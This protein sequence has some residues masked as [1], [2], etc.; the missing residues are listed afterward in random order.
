VRIFTQQLATATAAIEHIDHTVHATHAS[1]AQLTA[2]DAALPPLLAYTHSQLT[3]HMAAATPLWQ[4]WQQQSDT[5]HAALD[6]F[7][8]TITALAHIPLPLSLSGGRNGSTLLECVDERALR[9]SV[10]RARR[11]K[12]KS[13]WKRND[14]RR[15][16]ENVA[17]ALATIRS[18]LP[19]EEEAQV[20]AV[21]DGWGGSGSGG[22]S[23]D[24]SSSSSSSSSRRREC[25]GWMKRLMEVR[26]EAQHYCQSI[27][28]RLQSAAASSP[29]VL[30]EL[31]REVR[32]KQMEMEGWNR[33]NREAEE[34]GCLTYISHYRHAA[35][36]LLS[37]AASLFAHH[38]ASLTHCFTALSALSSLSA[39][40]PLYRRLLAHSMESFTP[41]LRLTRLSQSYSQSLSEVSRRQ[42]RRQRRQR[43]VTTV[44]ER[45]KQEESEERERRMRWWQQWGVNLPVGM[46]LGLKEESG[47]VKVEVCDWDGLLPVVTDEEVSRARQQGK[48]GGGGEMEETKEERTDEKEQ[49]DDDEAEDDE[50]AMK[51]KLKRLQ[52][53][54]ATLQAELLRLRQQ[55]QQQQPTITPTP[56]PATTTAAAAEELST[57]RTEVDRRQALLNDA[58]KTNAWLEEE[59]NKR[60]EELTIERNRRDKSER[61]SR[62]VAMKL[63][64]AVKE[65]T[66]ERLRYDECERERSGWRE[67]CSERVVLLQPAVNDMVMAVRVAG[68]G[69]GSSGGGSMPVYR[70][71]LAGDGGRPMF[72]SAETMSV[73]REKRSGSSSGGSGV[74][75]EWVVGHVVEL[76]GKRATGSVRESEAGLKIGE[77]YWMATV[78]LVDFLER[79]PTSEGSNGVEASSSSTQSSSSSVSSSSS[80]PSPS[81]ST[82]TLDTLLLATP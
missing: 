12:D 56:P 28:A 68:G 54:N 51:D 53:D 25:V 20:R 31:E 15:Q 76:V 50:L 47:W 24:S 8:P 60:E 45:W 63:V 40:L 30:A 19:Q 44:V 75:A 65:R 43:A 58:N 67:R 10:E 3:Q 61:D 81:P 46:Q 79:L 82:A 34:T 78:A 33:R 16:E 23:G 80:S 42:R 29:L 48:V 59:L 36:Q 37:F 9:E 52:A 64:S 77:E 71:R 62:E 4:Q 11:E 1:L 6:T 22:S 5:Q 7:E 57:L 35:T 66:R 32:V 2:I 72:L 13:E 14:A 26:D 49:D 73:M 18:Y 55:Q 39:S 74:W 41:L 38:T 70:V 17:A 27:E 69:D 21:M